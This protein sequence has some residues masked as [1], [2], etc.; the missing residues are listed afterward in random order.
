MQLTLLTLFVRLRTMFV[1]PTTGQKR[2]VRAAR[3]LVVKRGY[4]GVSLR[5]IASTAGYSPAG[6]YAHFS[7]REAILQALADIVRAELQAALNDAVAAESDPVKQLV[8]LGCTYVSF[9]CAQPAEFELLFR[10]ARS[11]RKSRAAVTLSTFDLLRSVARRAN[12]TLR[13]DTLDIACLGLW[14]AAHG[15]A[16]L[17]TSHL[18]DFPG[19]WNEWTRQVLQ[20]QVEGSLCGRSR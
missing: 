15:L 18:A 1:V 2:I 19:D 5:D 8:G 16:G 7:G 17:R 3:I 11:R 4:A 13:E 12:P 6:L 9:A 20:S 14:S 10:Y